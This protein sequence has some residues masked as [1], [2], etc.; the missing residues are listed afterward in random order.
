MVLEATRYDRGD[1]GLLPGRHPPYRSLKD[2]L[3]VHAHEQIPPS[4]DSH[5]SRGRVAGDIKLRDT[6]NYRGSLC[7]W[8]P[9]GK[10]GGR[11]LR[12]C[13][14]RFCSR[15]IPKTVREPVLAGFPESGLEVV[16]GPGARPIT[17][18]EVRASTCLLVVLRRQRSPRRLG[19]RRLASFHS[20]LRLCRCLERHRPFS[21]DPVRLHLCSLSSRDVGLRAV[22]RCT[23]GGGR[24]SWPPSARQP[25]PG[26]APPPVRC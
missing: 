13:Q 16:V 9:R 20:A 11:S 2:P 14:P 10:T 18:R 19:E 22:G 5:K 6:C 7:Y 15:E 4:L 26:G 25:P 8:F 17:E 1:D 21:L 12:P 3:Q 24:W 23:E